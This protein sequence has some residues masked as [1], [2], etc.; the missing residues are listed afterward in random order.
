[1]IANGKA[2]ELRIQSVSLSN[3]QS[4]VETQLRFA[5][6]G[7]LTVIVGPTDS[8]K[9][10][11]VRALKWVIYNQPAGTGFIRAGAATSTVSIELASGLR[12]TR[13]RSASLNQYRLWLPIGRHEAEEQVFEGFGSSVPAEVQRA[14]RVY[15]VSIGDLVL[16]VNLAEQLDGPFLGKSVPSTLRAK[17]LGRLA[18]SEVLDVASNRLGT[19]ILRAS[20]ERERLEHELEAVQSEIDRHS[21][22]IPML[23]KI[24]SADLAVSGINGKVQTIERCRE[25][26]EKLARLP[27]PLAAA[28]RADAIRSALSRAS[29]LDK[30]FSERV[31]KLQQVSSLLQKS[32]LAAQRVVTAAATVRRLR[33]EIRRVREAYASLAGELECCPTCGQRLPEDLHSDR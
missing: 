13:L 30:L 3:F 2:T 18:G 17:V 32:D 26:R 19:D 7:R 27:D 14:L 25:L 29:A 28:R 1:M 20:R 9:T 12:V 5:G 31:A 24:R 21:W 11:I 33:D 23:D 8:G 22:V 6:E 10:S 4:H 16:L 15:P